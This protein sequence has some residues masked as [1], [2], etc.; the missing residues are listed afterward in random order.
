M[1]PG[2][3]VKVEAGYAHDWVVSVVLILYGQVGSFVPDVGKVVVAGMK[4][5]KEGR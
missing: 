4:R 3:N 5:A 1:E 2:E